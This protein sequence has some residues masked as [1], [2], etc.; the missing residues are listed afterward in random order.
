MAKDDLEGMSTSTTQS[1]L[2][3]DEDETET[4][5]E[6][7]DTITLMKSKGSRKRGRTKGKGNTDAKSSSLKNG[8]MIV[9]LAIITDYKLYQ[10]WTSRSPGETTSKMKS[11]ILGLVNNVR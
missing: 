3:E 5:T 10:I 2:D 4:E 9:D 8:P 6:T 7:E 1:P 11:F